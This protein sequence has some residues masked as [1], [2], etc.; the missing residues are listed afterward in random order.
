MVCS[1]PRSSAISL[2]AER[3]SGGR[4]S[5]SGR[6]RRTRSQRG[7]LG[8]PHHVE[9]VGSLLLEVAHVRATQ[10]RRRSRPGLVVRGRCLRAS[11]GGRQASRPAAAA[12]RGPERTESGD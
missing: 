8:R 2:H 9:P 10:T 3:G 7:Q 1:S 5:R 12:A 6:P 4:R 11:G